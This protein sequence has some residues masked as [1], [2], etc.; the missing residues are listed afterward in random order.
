MY[1]FNYDYKH[2]I[3]HDIRFEVLKKQND[4]NTRIKINNTV[5]RVELYL[6]IFN[7]TIWLLK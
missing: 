5:L 1:L 7:V 6:F 3:N 2:K 4:F